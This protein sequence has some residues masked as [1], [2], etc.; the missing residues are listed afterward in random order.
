MGTALLDPS[1]ANGVS[2]SDPDV[3]DP[4]PLVAHAVAV[5][6]MRTAAS[7][8][9]AR[10]ACTAAAASVGHLTAAPR[11]SAHMAGLMAL[12]QPARSTAR[13]A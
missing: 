2:A 10:R 12:G 1:A 4:E 3:P 7:S 9:R 13:A 5:G 6:R 11:A 8:S